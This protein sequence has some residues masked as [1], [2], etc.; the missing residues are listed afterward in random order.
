MTVIGEVNLVTHHQAR[1]RFLYRG[2]ALPGGT[3]ILTVTDGFQW[4]HFQCRSEGD[5]M[6]CINGSEW[7]RFV[8]T[9]INAMITLYS[10]EDGE[11]FHRI[12]LKSG[13]SSV[14]TELRYGLYSQSNQWRR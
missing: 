4:W 9:R 11:D 13:A 14:Q 6:Y 10:K 2:H 7:S 5:N 12:R 8:Q 1:W 3:S